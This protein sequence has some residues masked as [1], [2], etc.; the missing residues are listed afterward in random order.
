MYRTRL[1]VFAVLLVTL[2]SPA[3][4]ASGEAIY[5]KHCAS[6]HSGNADNTPQLGIAEHW[7]VRLGYGRKSLV[8]S[9][10]HGHNMMP[11]HEYSMRVEDIEAALDYIVARAGGWPKR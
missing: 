7:R 9:V 1:T 2:S 10:R 3:L 6:C 5:D 11:T 4:A 8:D